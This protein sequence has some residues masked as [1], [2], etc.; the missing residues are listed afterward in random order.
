MGLSNGVD[1][2]ST[3]LTSLFICMIIFPI[4][5]F[6]IQKRNLN[7]YK[8]HG[9]SPLEIES[10]LK[11]RSWYFK[12]RNNIQ[13]EILEQYKDDNGAFHLDDKVSK[14]IDDALNEICSGQLDKNTIS[15]AFSWMNTHEGTTYW[16]KREYEFLKWYFGQYID[17][18]F[19]K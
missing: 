11:T 7:Y 17:L 8:L 13:N 4:G 14:E 2:M 3:F 12:F 5:V 19:F 15:N 16:G 9:R 10:W 6:F 18:H 1:K